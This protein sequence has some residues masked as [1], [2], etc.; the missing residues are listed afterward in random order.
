MI[1]PSHTHVVA[2]DLDVGGVRLH[3]AQAWEDDWLSATSADIASLAGLWLRTVHRERNLVRGS[4]VTD[5]FAVPEVVDRFNTISDNPGMSELPESSQ[6][7]LKVESVAHLLIQAAAFATRADYLEVVFVDPKGEQQ[8]ALCLGSDP[9]GGNGADAKLN[10]PSGLKDLLIST[11]R[12]APA[13]WASYP[14]DLERYE[15]FENVQLEQVRQALAVWKKTIGLYIGFRNGRKNWESDVARLRD[16]MSLLAEKASATVAKGKNSPRPTRRRPTQPTEILGSSDCMVKV[17]EKIH[18]LAKSEFDVLVLGETG[19]GKELVARKIHELSSRKDG[20]FVAVNISAVGDSMFE[21]E[22]FGHEKGAFT[23]ASRARDGAFQ[24]AH[25][26]TLFLDEIGD[27][28][29][30]LQTKLLRAIQ[31]KEVRRVGGEHDEWCDVRIVAATNR[32]LAEA[33]CGGAFRSDLF[34]RLDIPIILPALRERERDGVELAK[35]FLEKHNRPGWQLSQDAV[36]AILIHQFPGN[37]RELERAIKNAVVFGKG[38]M[39][40]ADDLKL[41]QSPVSGRGKARHTT[42]FANGVSKRLELDREKALLILNEFRCA[43]ESADPVLSSFRWDKDKG[44][45]GLPGR[46]ENAE[47]ETPEAEAARNFLDV[48]HVVL[49]HK[50]TFK[51]DLQGCPI[52]GCS[53]HYDGATYPYKFITTK[54][55]DVSKACRGIA[56]SRPPALHKFL[57]W[58]IGEE[59]EMETRVGVVWEQIEEWRREPES[60]VSKLLGEVES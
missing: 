10:Q 41:A 13:G 31:E 24:Q 34:F 22:L 30:R 53:G 28:D 1:E 15:A 35:Y 2:S 39:V 25:G 42:D 33:M 17:R 29:P 36:S 51:G 8:H 14:S 40:T 21:S 56:R 46:P 60:K 16:D 26:G 44:L 54:K 20:P 4:S 47:P 59:R 9:R 52:C 38:N 12:S 45:I 3:T 58:M 11:A 57:A 27:L 43:F 23:G 32:D 48:V 37:V 19:T 50:G 49:H 6:R 7:N 18:L 5:G 55:G